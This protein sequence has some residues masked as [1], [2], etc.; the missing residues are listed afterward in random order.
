MITSQNVNTTV[1]RLYY[2]TEFSNGVGCGETDADLSGLLK[3][4][5]SVV[6]AVEFLVFYSGEQIGISAAVHNMYVRTCFMFVIC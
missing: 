4:H 5:F 6:K 1:L 3:K 2:D